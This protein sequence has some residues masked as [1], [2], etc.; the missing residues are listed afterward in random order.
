MN[1]IQISIKKENGTFNIMNEAFNGSE[2]H[3]NLFGERYGAS[4]RYELKTLEQAER[5][6]T[7]IITAHNES[8]KINGGKTGRT[9][10]AV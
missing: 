8:E 7:E 1:T 4:K 9:A 10:I 2:P 3:A 6:R 5:C